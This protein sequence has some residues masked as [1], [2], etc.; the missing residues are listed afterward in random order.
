MNSELV[1]QL[2]DQL[3]IR[4]HT[5]GE[6]LGA[7]LLTAMTERIVSEVVPRIAAELKSDDGNRFGSGSGRASRVEDR[8]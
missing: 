5:L 6:L 4:A 1:D 7:D 3:N 8:P 2:T